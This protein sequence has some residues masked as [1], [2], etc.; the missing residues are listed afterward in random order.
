[1]QLS[2]P[3]TLQLSDR[4]Q[5]SCLT[6]YSAVISPVIVQLSHRFPGSGNT[7]V[8]GAP[9]SWLKGRGFESLRERRENSFFSGVNFLCWLLFW[10]LFH[11]RVT[12]VARKRSRSFCQ[13]YRWQVT[14]KH[15]HTLRVWLWLIDWWL[16]ISYIA[17][18]SALLSRLTALACGFTWVTSFL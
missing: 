7:S 13:K 14:A 5:C 9:D 11:H 3:V 10:Y 12:A 16:M 4:L 15:A 6:A 18:F 17:L 8:V 2:V 1:M